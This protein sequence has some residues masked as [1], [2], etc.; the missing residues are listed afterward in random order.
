FDVRLDYHLSAKDQLFA[1]YSYGQD[2][3]TIT[4]LFTNL[5]AG[6]ASG[7]NV[8]HPRGVAAGYTRIFT[9]NIVNEFRF[10]YTRPYYAYINPFQ[11]V[12]ISGNLGIVNAN[13]NSLLGGG[14]LIG[15]SNTEIAYTGDG[16]PYAV[17]QHTHQY[18]DALTWVHGPHTFKFGANIIRREVDFF[19][20]NDAKG[21]FIVGGMNDPGW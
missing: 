8:N 19:Q 15:G 12:P 17:P 6:F 1:R 3:N 5:P 18:A 21:S 9:P 10:G 4:S 2:N 11:G 7:N 16:G 14:A 13:R 20:V